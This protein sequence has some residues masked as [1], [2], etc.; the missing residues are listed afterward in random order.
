METAIV[1]KYPYLT[2]EAAGNRW[3]PVAGT[4]HGTLLPRNNRNFI[5]TDRFLPGV[6]DLGIDD[7][8]HKTFPS[9]LAIESPI[10]TNFPSQTDRSLSQLSNEIQLNSNVC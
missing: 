1:S 4:E 9:Q 5:G 2:Q 7:E 10:L 6:F 8:A 3:E